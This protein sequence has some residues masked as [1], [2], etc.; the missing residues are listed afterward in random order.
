MAVNEDPFRIFLPC[1]SSPETMDVTL[2]GTAMEESEPDFFNSAY[3]TAFNSPGQTLTDENL[4]NSPSQ[5]P[6]DCS[7][8]N[9]MNRADPHSAE[10]SPPDSSSDSSTRHKR[11]N[12][13]NSSQSGLLAGDISLTDDVH[14]T[15]WKSGVSIVEEKF[16]EGL[17]VEMPSANADIDLSNRAMENDFDF[18][19][20][21]SSPSPPPNSKAD[22]S[23]SIRGL[24]MPIRSPRPG[25]AF[26]FSHHLGVPNVSSETICR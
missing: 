10:S 2:A 1:F 25:P 12:S 6:P 4:S 22:F 14:S 11:N 8:P 13:S 21:A 3:T 17:K 23:G 15:T 24:K 19:S 20:A 5:S 18:E 16:A 9:A 26:S 7:R